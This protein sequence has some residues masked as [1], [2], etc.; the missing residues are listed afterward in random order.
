MRVTFVGA[1]SKAVRGNCENAVAGH[2]WRAETQPGPERK[3][4]IVEEADLAREVEKARRGRHARIAGIAPNNRM[5]GRAWEAGNAGCTRAGVRASVNFAADQP[6]TFFW[7]CSISPCVYP[8]ALKKCS[9]CEL[10]L[11]TN[12]KMV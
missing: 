5:R 2:R 1:H 12:V 11:L 8:R 6:L 4:F 7:K 9:I 10:P 3:A